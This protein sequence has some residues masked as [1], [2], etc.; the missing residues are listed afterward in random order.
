VGRVGA[1]S[2]LSYISPAVNALRWTVFAA[3]IRLV[4][5]IPLSPAMQETVVC[6]S[7]GI[8]W[9][10]VHNPDTVLRRRVAALNYSLTRWHDSYWVHSRRD[11]S[12]VLGGRWG[13]TA[14]I[15][16]M[17]TRHQEPEVIAQ[18]PK[19]ARRSSPS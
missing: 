16:E 19:H 15:V 2:Q 10:L 7:R 9:L 18:S 1:S 6:V 13:T 8:R 11:K 17:W 5:C 14:D 12:L 4:G 3:L